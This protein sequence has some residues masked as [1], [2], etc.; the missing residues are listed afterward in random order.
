VLQKF[1]PEAIYMAFVFP[2]EL[3][4]LHYNCR[5]C[6]NNDT[7]CQQ[8]ALNSTK[9]AMWH[10]KRIA[11]IWNLLKM[12]SFRDSNFKMCAL[13]SAP[14]RFLTVRL[15]GLLSPVP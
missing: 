1:R 13:S 11:V 14:H 15:V 2:R 3:R 12:L 10:A 7:F 5:P 4:W 6:Q 9:F 8:P